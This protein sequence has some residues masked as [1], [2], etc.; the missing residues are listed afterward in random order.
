MILKH[1]QCS[2]KQSKL[3]MFILNNNP[4]PDML[5]NDI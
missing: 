2:L 4:G 3:L 1:D 5:N